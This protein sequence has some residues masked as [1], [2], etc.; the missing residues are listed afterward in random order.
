M[1][2]IVTVTQISDISFLASSISVTIGPGFS[3]NLNID[4]SLL[5]PSCQYTIELLSVVSLNVHGKASSYFTC[6]I[7]TTKIPLIDSLPFPFSFSLSPPSFPVS[8]LPLFVLPK[9]ASNTTMV[10]PLTVLLVVDYRKTKNSRGECH[11]SRE[12][13]KG[14]PYHRAQRRSIEK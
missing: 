12:R 1:K 9:P 6:R 13:R 2:Y 4:T 8:F 5:I 3:S 14:P 11:S 10:G 7:W